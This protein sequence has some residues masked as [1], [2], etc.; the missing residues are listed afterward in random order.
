MLV[1]NS[2]KFNIYLIYFSMCFLS[3]ISITHYIFYFTGSNLTVSSTVFLSCM[4]FIKLFMAIVVVY[5]FKKESK[6]NTIVTLEN[7]KKIKIFAVCLFL[8]FSFSIMYT[9]ISIS[10]YILTNNFYTLPFSNFDI[11]VLGSLFCI[12]L[13]YYGDLF[14]FGILQMENEKKIISRQ[15]NTLDI[16]FSSSDFT[17]KMNKSLLVIQIAL[18]LS[19]MF[20]LIKIITITSNST[21]N[22][23]LYYKTN[24]NVYTLF[25]SITIIFLSEFIIFYAFKAIFDNSYKMGRFFLVKNIKYFRLIGLILIISAI[26]YNSVL[27]HFFSYNEHAYNIYLF[28]S[29]FCIGL[30]IY[31]LSNL[32]NISFK[33]L[34]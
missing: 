12:L 20:F 33:Q 23:V 22:D 26:I 19:C 18:L 14:K 1:S 25:F 29:I 4:T 8:Y 6:K 17:Y 13:F 15:Y 31:A 16:N 27:P 11:Y 24:G 28:Y 34:N 3:L 5:Y 2:F 9:Q 21:I 30:F 10:N 7:Y 32:M